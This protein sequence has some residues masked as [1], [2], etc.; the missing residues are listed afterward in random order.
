M[1]DR[2][3][4]V[5]AN[6]GNGGHRLARILCCFENVYWYSDSRNGVHPWEVY[7]NPDDSK[8]KSKVSGKDISP[9]HFDRYIGESTAPLVGERIEKYWNPEDLDYFY[10]FVWTRE[11]KKSGA[12]SVVESKKFLVWV[13]HDDP[14]YI[15]QRFPG[16]LIINLIDDSIK[17]TVDRYL[18]TTALFPI[19]IKNKNLKPAYQT[20]YSL[21]VDDL[22]AINHSACFRDL[23]AFEH[24]HN[25]YFDTEMLTEYRAYIER[26]LGDLDQKK[27]RV[28]GKIHSLKWSTFDLAKLPIALGSITDQRIGVLID[29]N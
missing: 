18:R 17:D 8:G 27:L 29:E 4:F 24:Y 14:G 7:Y 15:L 28:S 2:L 1:N 12:M 26:Y 9:Y 16:S 10:K 21:L 3:L 5:C 11:M 19:E 20:D 6:P 22:L 23:W 13:V 25:P